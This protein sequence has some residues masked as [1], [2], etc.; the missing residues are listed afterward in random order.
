MCNIVLF[1][2]GNFTGTLTLKSETIFKTLQIP[3]RWSGLELL[4]ATTQIMFLHC[5]LSEKGSSCV[6]LG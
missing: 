1:G 2:T 5:N 4:A 3:E 6:V